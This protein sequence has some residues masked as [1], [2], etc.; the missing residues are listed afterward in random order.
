MTSFPEC[1]HLLLFLCPVYVACIEGYQQL[2]ACVGRQEKSKQLDSLQSELQL[3]DSDIKQVAGRQPVLPTSSSS[4][5]QLQPPSRQHSTQLLDR[6]LQ[7]ASA[8]TSSRT[9]Q[10]AAAPSGH[11]N[12][13]SPAA[14]TGVAV[15]SLQP[16]QVSAS[17]RPRSSGSLPPGSSA[18]AM[19]PTPALSAHQR[20]LMHP[21]QPSAQQASAQPGIILAH[22]ALS[23]QPASST[24]NPDSSLRQ[25]LSSTAAANSNQS[26][27]PRLARASNGYLMINHPYPSPSGASQQQG[28]DGTATAAHGNTAPGASAMLAAARTAT[29]VPIPT[30]MERQQ[31]MHIHPRHLAFQHFHAQQQRQQMERQHSAS[32][33]AAGSGA[34]GIG[35]QA[36]SQEAAL[37]YVTAFA[38]ASHVQVVIL[39]VRT[40]AALCHCPVPEGCSLLELQGKGLWQLVAV[41]VSSQ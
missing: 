18:T 38:D 37:R 23:Q 7:Q 6:R 13:A 1:F 15:G 33:A 8:I 17:I 11:D 30:Q 3:L 22:Q 12:E 20:S 16:V 39:R 25:H 40:M 32:Q 21:A 26:L 36:A 19:P 29:A 24:A 35:D 28:T 27:Q 4:P 41:T 5:L 14:A 9:K 31:S 2:V 34:T 10:A